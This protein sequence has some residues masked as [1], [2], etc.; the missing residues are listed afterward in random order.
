MTPNQT[1]PTARQN[2]EEVS[3]LG[4][5]VGALET[6][7]DKLEM[8]MGR[9]TDAVNSSRGTNWSLV[10]AIVGCL[11]IFLGGGWYLIRLQ[12][13]NTVAPVASDGEISKRE[14]ARLAVL[15]DDHAHRVTKT[16]GDVVEQETQQRANGQIRNLMDSHRDQIEAII[17][18]QQ[19][20][21]P[22][23]RSTYYPDISLPKPSK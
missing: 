1:V 9:L 5:R 22:M 23:P 21:F 3:L 6:R 19:F 4:A 8:A 2:G 20:G 12:T 13:E 15:Q 17:F 11:T 14:R 16:E 10:V 18:E 7:F